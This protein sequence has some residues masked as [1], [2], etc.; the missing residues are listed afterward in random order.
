[1][2]HDG[3][4]PS[5]TGFSFEDKI[6]A[7]FRWVRRSVQNTCDAM[8]EFGLSPDDIGA[9][10]IVLAEVLN[11]IVEHG[12]DEGSDDKIEIALK[13]RASSLMIE[14]C[15]RG[16]P[17]P[18]GRLPVGNHPMS[19]F[20]QFDSMPEGGYGWFLIRELV[21]DIVYDRK[22]GKNMLM[23]RIKLSEPEDNTPGR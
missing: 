9:V 13:S 8:H 19:E 7:D 5:A 16:R 20:N 1:M 14:I 23:I 3:T 10:E 12:Y 21:R 6:P 15:D 22:D 11:N 18:K 2:P 4:T 17:M